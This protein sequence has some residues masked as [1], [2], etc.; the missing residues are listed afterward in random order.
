MPDIVYSTSDLLV[1]DQAG[2]TRLLA[3]NEAFPSDHP[4]V[5]ARPELFVEFPE[6]R[7]AAGNVVEQSTA[8]PGERRTV[9]RG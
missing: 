8:A 7:D 5:K 2:G 3:R 1:S 4:I 9:R 6:V